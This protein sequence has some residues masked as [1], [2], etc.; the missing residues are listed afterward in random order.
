[1]QRDYDPQVGR[2][3]E[4]DLMGLAAGINTYAYA[5]SSPSMLVDPL[6]LSTSCG[7][8]DRCAQLRAQ[9]FSKSASLLKQLAKYDPIADGRGGWQSS[10]G[11]T[12]APGGHYDRI[13]QLQQGLKNDI[14]EYKRLCSNNGDWPNVPRSIDET[15][16]QS[17]TEPIIPDQEKPSD[18]PN[19]QYSWVAAAGAAA[20]WLAR[21]IALAL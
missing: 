5:N 4:S 19:S 11:R 1:M 12:T 8:D 16:N 6:G 17:V 18:H 9:I 21:A 10:G 3:V 2:Y 7:R 14:A 15:A 13:I 20:L